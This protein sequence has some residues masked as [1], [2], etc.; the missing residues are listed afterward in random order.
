M[1]KARIAFATAILWTAFVTGT[2]GATTY[3]RLIGT[4]GF[5]MITL[6]DEKGRT[7]TRLKAGR[8]TVAVFDR[9]STQNFH[10][11]GPH[12]NRYTTAKFQGARTWT[13][14]F[15]KG[16]T[17][18]YFSDRASRTLKGSFKVT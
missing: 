17:I 3:P 10:L 11:L 1:T 16:T 4:V 5:G 15:R 8:Y 12:I 7:I 13:V 6:K 2:A 9:S 18:K 14:T